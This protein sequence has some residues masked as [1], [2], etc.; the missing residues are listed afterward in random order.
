MTIK[1][2][3]AGDQPE[4]REV[5]TYTGSVKDWPEGV[6]QSGGELAIKFYGGDAEVMYISDGTASKCKTLGYVYTRVSD[7]STILAITFAG[8]MN[9]PDGKPD[10]VDEPDPIEAACEE[11]RRVCDEQFAKSQLSDPTDLK[12]G[13]WVYGEYS[14]KC[15]SVCE[16]WGS[17]FKT[18]DGG[19]W[20]MNGVG[21]TV[22]PAPK[23]HQ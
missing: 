20:P 5:K 16:V 21:Y 18:S 10:G 3:F 1:I 11:I 19:I 22:V 4:K 2:E 14:E 8:T 15:H 7:N 17:G 6:Y 13:D 12:V 23:D 9:Y